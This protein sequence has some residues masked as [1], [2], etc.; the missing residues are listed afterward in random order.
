[1][2]EF[3]LHSQQLQHQ[4]DMTME[5]D[6]IQL[7]NISLEKEKHACKEQLENLKTALGKMFSASQIT[8][9]MQDK[10]VKSWEKEDIASGISL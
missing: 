9:L 5:R 3:Q 1:M 10:P 8:S 7:K 6:I 2:K 4:V